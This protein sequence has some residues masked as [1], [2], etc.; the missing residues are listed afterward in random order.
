MEMPGGIFAYFGPE[1]VLP[2]TSVVVAVL[3]AVLLFGRPAA[4][5]LARRSRTRVAE[6]DREVGP[7][8]PHFGA[9][10]GRHAGAPAS[11]SERADA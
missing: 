9:G 3:G 1:A 11:G 8:G 6:A 4:R 2:L 10:R 7:G 5:L